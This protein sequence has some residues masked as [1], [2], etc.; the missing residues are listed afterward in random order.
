MIY[1]FYVQ[2][3][4]NMVRCHNVSIFFISLWTA[5]SFGFAGAICLLFGAAGRYKVLVITSMVANMV[6]FI[7]FAACMVELALWFEAKARRI[8]F[9]FGGLFELLRLV[10][11]VSCRRLLAA[12]CQQRTHLVSSAQAPWS[13]GYAPWLS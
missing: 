10:S 2:V 6:T 13:T 12:P 8:K 1:W 11:S 4:C 9:E 7:L 5:C 3:H